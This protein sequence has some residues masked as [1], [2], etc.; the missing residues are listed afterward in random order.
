MHIYESVNEPSLQSLFLVSCIS[1]GGYNRFLTKLC[2][3]TKSE[4]ASW[5]S[6]LEDLKSKV[7]YYLA[8][9]LPIMS[10]LRSIYIGFQLELMIAADEM[11]TSSHNFEGVLSMTTSFSGWF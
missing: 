11:L 2:P 1:R 10:S 8:L 7:A 5:L 9:H 3:I 4:K 6:R